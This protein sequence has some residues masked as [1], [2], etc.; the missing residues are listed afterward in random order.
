MKK[1][2]FPD[3]SVINSFVSTEE[4]L[5]DF[6]RFVPYC[7]EHETVWSPRLASIILEA[8]SQLDSLWQYQAKL[9]SFV[10]KERLTIGHYFSYYGERMGS[11]WLLFY[12]ESSE[13]IH[14]Y[15]PWD[16]A[17]NYT[18]DE[19]PKHELE[20]WKAYNKLKHNRFLNQSEAQLKYAVLSVAGLFMAILACESCREAVG[21]VEWL[22]GSD[23]FEHK[24][25]VHLAEDSPSSKSHWVTA[26][27]KLFT[28]AVGWGMEPWPE[29]FYWT[30]P[31][32]LRFKQWADQQMYL[33]AGN[34]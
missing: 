32:S 16:T 8:C 27:S 25:Y 29:R 17:K 5:S 13:V 34:P 9:S 2:S 10:P 6:L 21:R 3:Q 7:A 15:I 31:C 19:Y 4:A 28:Y 1:M 33:T 30:G 20:W 26:E 18:R 12:G 23:I 24:L 14:P 22:S 11:K